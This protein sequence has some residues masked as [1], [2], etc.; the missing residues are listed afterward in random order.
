MDIEKLTN[1]MKKVNKGMEKFMPFL[2]PTGVILGLILGHRIAHLKPA[3]N[4]LF[5][6]LT[7]TGAISISIKDFG[8]TLKKPM[9]FLCYALASYI[10]MPIIAKLGGTIVF[11]NSPNTVSGY[12]L[13]RSIPSAVSGIIWA[14]IYSGNMAICLSILILD[15]LIA[16][17][18]TP[19]L[20]TLHSGTAI[21]VDF[22]GMVTSLFTMVVI[23]SVVGMIA[24]QYKKGA[25]NKH[26]GPCLKPISKVALLFVL[27]INAAQVSDRIIENASMEYVAIAI[28]SLVI[29][30]IGFVVSFFIAKSF[31]LNREDSISVT[32][33][34]AMRNISAAL[35]LAIDYLPPEAALPCIFGIVFQQSI[36]AIMGNVLFKERHKTK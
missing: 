35:V 1:N 21:E 26:V 20:F 36:C 2:T 11:P 23:P 9:F 30:V 24:N 14:T 18:M 34:V 19:F 27:M 3:V 31:K 7:F 12:I 10:L 32:F 8:R 15:T 22:I 4:Y 13:L 25:I 17:I 5:A 6:F 29:T 33:S 16:P 28:S